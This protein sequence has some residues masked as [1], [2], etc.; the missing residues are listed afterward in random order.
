MAMANR[1]VP[2]SETR[3]LTPLQCTYIDL[4]FYKLNFKTKVLDLSVRAY[5]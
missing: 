4:F 5:D 2:I 3:N 1:S